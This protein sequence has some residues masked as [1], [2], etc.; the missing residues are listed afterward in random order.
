MIG[1]PSCKKK[2]LTK[3]AEVSIASDLG[4]QLADSV[5]EQ[6]E[7]WE[8]ILTSHMQTASGHFLHR[9]FVQHMALDSW[10]LTGRKL[11]GMGHGPVGCH[12]SKMLFPNSDILV[13]VYMLPLVSCVC[14]LC[15]VTEGKDI[16]AFTEPVCACWPVCG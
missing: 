5:T 4:A 11:R 14:K 1:F 3:D 7:T 10:S 2:E 13:K 16:L 9:G 15:C 12:R 8:A 6:E